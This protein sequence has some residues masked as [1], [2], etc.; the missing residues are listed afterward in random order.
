MTTA[1]FGQELDQLIRARYALVY[2]VTWEED[3]ARDLLMRI[4]HHRG[5]D[6]YE[7]SMT[8]GLRHVAGPS[9]QTKTV[10]RLREPLKVLNEILQANTDAVYV[11]KDFHKCLEAPE[12]I[13]HVRD[14]GFALRRSK[15][16]LIILSPVVVIPPELEK[17][18]TLIDMPLPG[19]DD[20]RG[21]LRRIQN[22]SQQTRKFRVDLSDSQIDQI[23]DA[24][25]GL[26]M[27]E[28]ENA[29]AMS[30]IRDGLLDG[31]DIQAIVEEKRQIIR[32]SGVLEYY[33]VD[34]S[35]SDVGGMDILKDWLHKRRSAFTPEAREYGLPHPNGILLMGVQGCGK[36][37]IVKAISADWKMPL[38]RMDMS[39]IFQSYI[40]SSEQNMRR[41]LRMAEELA[42][43]ILWIDEIEKAFSG[44][45]G[46][47]AGDSGTTSRVVGMFL[48]WL[49]EKKGPVFVFAT[50]NEVRSL[51]PEL[52]RKGRLDEIFFVDLPRR[53][54]RQTILEIH[55]KKRKR[56]PA[57]YDLRTLRRVCKG[58]SGAEIEQAVIS[59]MHDSFFEKRELETRDIMRAFE[60]SV[61]L[62]TTMRERIEQLR[63]SARRR[64]RP[65]SSHQ[66]APVPEAEPD[67][68]AD[69]DAETNAPQPGAV[70]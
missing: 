12:V 19:K 22:E 13:R 42:P 43:I 60:E 27:S 11:L 67:A 18:V 33:E 39:R 7:W 55:L 30:I 56:D 28:A 68:E 6:L 59:A 63:V 1:E 38:L 45:E 49:Q 65:V 23:T 35:F 52:L 25:R 44:M 34:D 66:S 26:T 20:L 29:F 64:A 50:A 69:A 4:C 8:D 37:L 3:R 57:N 9:A 32:K 54:E 31:E 24:A 41:A 62:S 53:Q 36:S 40:G 21:L 5:K 70:P 17:T 61:P 16:S 47:G 14:L 51:P 58:F 10:D 15:K 2:L 48:T 46:S